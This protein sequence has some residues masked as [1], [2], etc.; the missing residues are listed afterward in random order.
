VKYILPYKPF[1][2]SFLVF[3]ISGCAT[4]APSPEKHLQS[5]L[6]KQEYEKALQFVELESIKKGEQTAIKKQRPHI[7][8]LLHELESAAILTAT[9]HE[10]DGNIAIALSHIENALEK[11]PSSQRLKE[12]Y[13][14]LEGEKNIRLT[15]TENRLALAQAKFLLQKRTL[16]SEKK[17]A[18]GSNFSNWWQSRKTDAALP[19][20]N[21]KLLEC[22]KKSIERSELKLAGE[23]L[24]VAQ[25]IENNK[26]TQKALSEWHAA[27]ENHIKEQKTPDKKRAEQLK[28]HPKT[29]Y[30]EEKTFQKI[31][32]TRNNVLL[33]LTKSD[34]NKVSTELELLRELNGMNPELEQIIEEKIQKLLRRGTRL[35]RSG[36]IKEARD[37][38]Q[39]VLLLEPANGEAT[40][41]VE[42]A[43]RVL[44]RL[45]ELSTE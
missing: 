15:R 6:K 31:Q 1:F 41:N 11:I 36:E 29:N 3:I 26:T 39:R 5:L 33:S 16:I 7:K 21:K 42:R 18:E 45:E 4:L 14:S 9:K 27:L 44:K 38:W 23:C 20:L 25:K 24:Y 28:K 12:Y 43:E 32:D 34:Y 35:Y 8:N 10:E 37:V 30:I 2:V 22:G 13:A 40:V 19:N 17:R